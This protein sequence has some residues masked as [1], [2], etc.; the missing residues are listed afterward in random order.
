[1]RLINLVLN[2]LVVAFCETECHRVWLE[3]CDE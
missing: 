1:M 3:S 2:A